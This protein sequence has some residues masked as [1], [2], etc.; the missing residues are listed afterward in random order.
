MVRRR[1]LD[2]IGA[3]ILSPAS[4]RISFCSRVVMPPISGVP[5]PG[6]IEGSSTSMSMLT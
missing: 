4:L 6:A 3:A 1:H 5:V 2:E